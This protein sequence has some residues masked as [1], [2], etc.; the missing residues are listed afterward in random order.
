[1]V[2]EVNL[3][4]RKVVSEFSE[5]K[6]GCEKDGY[7]S[8]IL[9]SISG[10]ARCISIMGLVLSNCQMSILSCCYFISDLFTGSTSC[11]SVTISFPTW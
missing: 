11:S 3:E 9:S 1:V 4:N 6:S 5:T 2:E 8:N 7:C 10:G